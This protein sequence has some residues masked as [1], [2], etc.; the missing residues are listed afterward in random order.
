ML[1]K[2]SS[3]FITMLFN[4]LK[5]FPMASL[6]LFLSFA[7]VVSSNHFFGYSNRSTILRLS[8][9]A[10]IAFPLMVAIQIFCENHIYKKQLF[11]KVLLSF[12]A[13]GFNVL[14]FFYFFTKSDRIELIRCLSLFLIFTVTAMILLSYKNKN[15]S[16]EIYE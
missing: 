12:S 4:V 2:V 14:Y 1:K 16:V 15:F 11:Y 10:F 6:M 9:Q 3:Y 7:A 5:R 13:I 8:L